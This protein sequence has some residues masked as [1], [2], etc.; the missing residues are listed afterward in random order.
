MKVSGQLHASAALSPAPIELDAS[1]AL[2][3]LW[4]CFCR[5]LNRKSC[6]LVT[7]PAVLWLMK[8]SLS[9]KVFGA[10][11][12]SSICGRPWL[13]MEMNDQPAETSCRFF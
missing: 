4:T 7:I 9:M 1:L 2:A 5:G 10:G 6:V 8:A 11:E 12:E 13:W 3:S